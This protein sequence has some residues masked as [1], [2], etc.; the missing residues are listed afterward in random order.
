[1]DEQIKADCNWGP[2][3]QQIVKLSDLRKKVATPLT[4]HA[5]IIF[6]DVKASSKI[7]GQSSSRDWNRKVLSWI[8]MH[9]AL[10]SELIG[11]F[12]QNE[13]HQGFI[14]KTVGDAA[15]IYCPWDLKKVI[16]FSLCLQCHMRD[17]NDELY[18]SSSKK[19][20]HSIQELTRRIPKPKLVSGKGE[21]PVFFSVRLGF[22]YGK[23][24][25]MT[26][27]IQH[28][29]FVDFF[30]PGVNLASRM[31]SKICEIPGGIAFTVF[32]SDSS[33][34]NSQRSI[35]NAFHNEDLKDAIKRE[36]Y[37][38]YAIRTSTS[39]RDLDIAS[40]LHG[41]LPVNQKF[42]GGVTN[43]NIVILLPDR[44]NYKTVDDSAHSLVTGKGRL[45]NEYLDLLNPGRPR[46]DYLKKVKD[47]VENRKKR[48]S[49][50]KKD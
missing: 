41:A 44:S 10:M 25:K 48:R 42:T 45:R 27:P 35:R 9:F 38:G 3:S 6:T 34:E 13:Q 20:K 4:P 31:E 47:R 2:C 11:I 22:C 17:L 40:R 36:Y 28:C 1:M 32:S 26:S 16:L 33:F 12:N 8:Q 49:R 37:Q 7:W 50:S 29:D 5:A 30:G 14:V 19:V 18:R 21:P 39:F 15:M 24:R 46:F 43:I 23:F